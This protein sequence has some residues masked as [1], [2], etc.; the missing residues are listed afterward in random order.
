MA[1]GNEQLVLRLLYVMPKHID[2]HAPPSAVR[3]GG[4]KSFPNLRREHFR[5]I[6]DSPQEGCHALAQL[7]SPRKASG[8][9][10]FPNTPLDALRMEA[11]GYIDESLGRGSFQILPWMFF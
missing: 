2:R 11:H 6:D 3:L 5:I 7:L 8:R 4:N 9:V 1:F 10:G